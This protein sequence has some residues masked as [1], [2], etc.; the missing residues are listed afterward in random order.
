[1]NAKEALK[2][3]DTVCSQVSMS[4]DGHNKVL[5]AIN[6]LEKLVNEKFD[7]PAQTS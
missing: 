5:V 7:V 6:I 4:R 3:I 2:I 1:M